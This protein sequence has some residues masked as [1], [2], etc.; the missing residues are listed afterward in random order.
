MGVCVLWWLFC[1]K[2]IY[3]LTRFDLFIRKN[4]NFPHNFFFPKKKI[5]NTMEIF[6]N[7]SKMP[8]FMIWSKKRVNKTTHTFSLS[9]SISLCLT[10][11]SF[12]RNRNRWWRNTASKSHHSTNSCKLLGTPF[13]PIQTALTTF[14]NR[15][16]NFT[17]HITATP[18]AW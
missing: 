9:L 15:W 14:T 3:F 8:L 12:N 7:N 6:S 18:S 11:F 13:I 5:N 2:L 1:I 17:N 4:N 10:R 16:R